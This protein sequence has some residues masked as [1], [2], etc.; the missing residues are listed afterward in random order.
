MIYRIYEL[1]EPK[2]LKTVEQAG[3]DIKTTNPITLLELDKWSIDK[4]HSSVESALAEIQS[5][6]HD[7]KGKTLTIIP[8]VR[9][10][11]VDDNN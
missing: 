6:K 10:S 5:N 3:Y 11:Y 7:L 4:E 8:I 9:I 1:I 2:L